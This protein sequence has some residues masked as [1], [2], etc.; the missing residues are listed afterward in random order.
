MKN[1]C[2]DFVSPTLDKLGIEPYFEN[3]L[4]DIIFAQSYL[5]QANAHG[6]CI[7]D[8]M[9]LIQELRGYIV[10]LYW[11]IEQLE[12]DKRYLLEKRL[13]RKEFVIEDHKDEINQLEKELRKLIDY[14]E[15]SAIEFGENKVDYYW[16]AV[17]LLKA[18]YRKYTKEETK[19]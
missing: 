17:N 4:H 1:G 3:R 13:K 8:S 6:R 19:C 18:G 5:R 12:K 7:E 9:Q 2:K 10:Y 14:D 11:H 16:T 15:W